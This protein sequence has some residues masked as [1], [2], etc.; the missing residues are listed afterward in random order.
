M[1]K[2]YKGEVFL[3]YEFSSE[4]NKSFSR[5]ANQILFNASL[6]MIGGILFYVLGLV[7]I[8]NA[9]D[10]NITPALSYFINGILQFAIGISII[11]SYDNF[12][13]ITKTEGSDIHELITALKDLNFAFKLTALFVVLVI[14]L[15][16]YIG[17][18]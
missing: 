13:N 17:L 9:Y 14:L 18:I 5:L 3:S 12:N 6:F 10:A 4:E 11:R 15:E 2:N 1:L 16:Y 8:M 7:K